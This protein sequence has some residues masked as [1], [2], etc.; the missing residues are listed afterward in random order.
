LKRAKNVKKDAQEVDF[1]MGRVEVKAKPSRAKRG[2]AAT[3]VEDELFAESEDTVIP[4]RRSKRVTV[5]QVAEEPAKRV[6]VTKKVAAV[7]SKIVAKKGNRRGRKAEAEVA[8]D[9]KV[10]PLRKTR[11]KKIIPEIPLVKVSRQRRTRS[12]DDAKGVEVEAAPVE[13]IL[14]AAKK[15][16]AKNEEAIEEEEEGVVEVTAKKAPVKKAAAAKSLF[17]YI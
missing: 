7:K 9:E 4:A 10:A 14:A 17:S 13:K 8:E 15:A 11:P 12:D 16:A 6:K 2:K 5:T 3:V 1:V